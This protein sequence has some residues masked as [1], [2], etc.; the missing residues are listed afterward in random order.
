[1]M[2]RYLGLLILLLAV[3]LA[4]SACGGGGDDDDKVVLT[5]LP[6]GVLLPIVISNDLA[7]GENRFQIGLINQEDNSQVLGADLHLRFFVLQGS[8]GTLKFE[9]DPEPI[10][11][12]KTYTHTHEDGTVETHEAGETGAYVAYISFD[13]AG[14]WGVEVTG[15]TADGAALEPLRPTFSVNQVAAG[16]AV[17]DP[18][19]LSEQLTLADVDDI[20]DIDTSQE[21]IEAQHDKTIAEAVASGKPTVIAFATPAYCQTQICGP[22]KEIFDDLY[23]TYGDEANFVHIEPYDVPRM[24]SGD[25]A[26]LSECLVPTLDE[27]RLQ[28]EPWV[29]VVDA[30]G[31]IAAKFDGIASYEEIEAALQATL[32]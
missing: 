29:F 19:P 21:P 26:S 14:Q 5:P 18:A 22:T 9:A 1:M 23:G 10:V 13:E 24:R 7:V 8:E 12:T 28:S 16:L 4:A 32:A 15:T 27:W 20:R 3:A 31:K 11:I 30:E 2:R 17:G 25:C 6:E